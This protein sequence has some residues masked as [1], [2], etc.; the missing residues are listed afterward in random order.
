MRDS[1]I[2][3]ALAAALLAPAV[4]G[5]AAAQP[6]HAAVG[7][8]VSAAGPCQTTRDT[9]GSCSIVN[10]HVTI[11]FPDCHNHYVSCRPVILHTPRSSTYPRG[12]TVLVPHW[13]NSRDSVH[14]GDRVNLQVNQQG[15][16]A[17]TV[18]TA[19][20]TARTHFAPVIL[21][22]PRGGYRYLWVQTKTHGWQRVSAWKRVASGYTVTQPGVYKWT[23]R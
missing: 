2:S 9:T 8:Q 21:V 10:T 12:L 16:I 19:R 18:T 20:G 23:Y 4:V 17:L 11:T 1:F 6:V 3:R 7:R 13:G 14:T 22:A 15:L 5:V